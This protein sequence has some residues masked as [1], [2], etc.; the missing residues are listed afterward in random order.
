M[1]ALKND[2]N[3]VLKKGLVKE[4]LRNGKSSAEGEYIN[5]EKTVSGNIIYEMDC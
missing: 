1:E 4:Y 2:T 3:G 5:G